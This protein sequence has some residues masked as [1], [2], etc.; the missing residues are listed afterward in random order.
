MN[1]GYESGD[2]VGAFDEKKQK[3]KISCKFTF[4]VW[5]FQ[6]SEA[7]FE[8]ALWTIGGFCYEKPVVENLVLLSHCDTNP[9]A[10]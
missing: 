6:E 8:V 5:I 2:R 4:K 10:R 3:S 1:L 9:V 7:V